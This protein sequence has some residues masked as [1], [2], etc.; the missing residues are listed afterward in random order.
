[1][2]VSVQR[3]HWETYINLL[4]GPAIHAQRFDLGDVGTELAMERGASHA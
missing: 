1:M 4:I 2:S 3:Y